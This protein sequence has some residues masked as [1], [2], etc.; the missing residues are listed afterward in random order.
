METRSKQRSCLPYLQLAIL[1]AIERY[2]PLCGYRLYKIMDEA[3]LRVAEAAVYSA[4]AKLR[5]RGLIEKYEENNR[6]A[7]RVRYKITEAGRIELR[8]L[9]EEK[10]RIDRALDRITAGGALWEKEE[11]MAA[12]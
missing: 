8:N 7:G 9:W 12:Q 6:R 4:L 10:K 11:S 2:G 5:E 3:G 1:A